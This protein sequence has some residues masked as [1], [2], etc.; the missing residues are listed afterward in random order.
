MRSKKTRKEKEKEEKAPPLS[1]NPMYPVQR[2]N[3]G[4]EEQP[5]QLANRQEAC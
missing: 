3:Q 4:K 1:Q 2:T 5:K